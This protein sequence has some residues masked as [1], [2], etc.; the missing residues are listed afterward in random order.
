[1]KTIVILGTGLAAAPL[2]RQ[3]MIN[4]VLKRDDLKLVVVS[5]TDHFLWPIA[6]PRAVV[7]GQLAD[8]KVII[9][10]EPS[11]AEYPA[12]KF[13]FVQGKASALEPDS[14]LVIV[15]LDA[16][17]TQSKAKT[18]V[19]AGG[20]LTGVETAGK[21]SFEYSK[22]GKKEI[23]FIHGG[24]LPLGSPILDSVRKIAKNELEKLKVKIITN[25]TVV[26]TETSG[27][28]TII[29]LRSSDGTTKSI[30]AQAYLPATGVIPNTKFVPATLKNGQV[31][32]KQT[33][34]LH[35]EGQSNILVVGDAGNLEG[36]KAQYV[37]SQ[38]L[39]LINNLASYL[40]T[41]EMP[42]YVVNPKEVFGITVGRSRATGQMGT[43]KLFSIMV[44][45]VKGRYLGTDYSHLW[46]AGK[47]TSSKTFEK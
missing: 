45:F 38:T 36:C 17:V 10:L 4:I 12:S 28:N 29:T 35:V 33:K 15:E 6:M 34:T 26:S 42:E 41:G 43:F 24:S 2:I 20:G 47:R 30:T 27:S 11:F 40:N 1:M 31:Y 3:T 9:P 32:I 13:E 16:G 8:E 25:S 7:P 14:N 44:W 5:P 22:D 37:D 23:I 46:A 18:I 39:H 21:L 19:V